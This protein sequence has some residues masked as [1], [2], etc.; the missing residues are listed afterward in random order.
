MRG[1]DKE[2]FTKS[3]PM[4]ILGEKDPDMQSLENKDYV[5]RGTLQDI[6]NQFAAEYMISN[7]G[8]TEAEAKNKAA[9][10][11]METLKN[12]KVAG[13]ASLLTGEPIPVVANRQQRRREKVI[14]KK[15]ARK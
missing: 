11:V 9:R 14:N 2:V 13:L 5:E 10:V 6:I 3:M 4:C 8:S 1:G 15:M 7:P 12:S